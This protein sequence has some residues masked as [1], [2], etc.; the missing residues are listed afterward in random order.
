MKP[1]TKNKTKNTCS[2]NYNDESTLFS[3][4]HKLYIK[5]GATYKEDFNKQ[6]QKKKKKMERKRERR[7]ETQ[8]GGKSRR[9]N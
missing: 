8:Q 9:E 5:L 2:L 7:N 1:T 4:P 3:D 6:S